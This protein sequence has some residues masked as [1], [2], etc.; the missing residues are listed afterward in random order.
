MAI[1]G[2]ISNILEQSVEYI[3]ITTMLAGASIPLMLKEKDKK[4]KRE[5]LGYFISSYMFAIVSGV[6]AKNTPF[7]S[8]FDYL[9]TA[10]MYIT[11]PATYSLVRDKTLLDVLRMYVNSKDGKKD[12][13]GED[14]P[15]IP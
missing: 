11:G 13:N 9:I 12:G 8:D 4:H 10:T 7:L 14:P 6:I 3:G 1:L 15:L 5:A 2:K